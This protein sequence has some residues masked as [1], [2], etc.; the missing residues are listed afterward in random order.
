[1]RQRVHTSAVVKANIEEVREIYENQPCKSANISLH[2]GK[3]EHLS[4]SGV[5]E[6]VNKDP[7]G[8]T[9]AVTDIAEEFLMKYKG[10]DLLPCDCWSDGFETVTAGETIKCKSCDEHFDVDDIR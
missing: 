2:H 8:N 9:W 4:W 10:S 1:M 7:R 3:M 5:I 6:V